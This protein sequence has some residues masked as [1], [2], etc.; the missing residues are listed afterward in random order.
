MR[1]RH[2]GPAFN[3]INSLLRLAFR[4]DLR[5]NNNTRQR[6]FPVGDL[7]TNA[8]LARGQYGCAAV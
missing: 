7:S 8:G 6:V 1:R 5:S 2:G 3:Y 4:D